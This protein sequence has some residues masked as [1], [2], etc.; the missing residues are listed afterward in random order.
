[1]TT[2]MRASRMA[3]L[4]LL[5]L[6]GAA[7]MYFSTSWIR[8]YNEV[9]AVQVSDPCQRNFTELSKL[10]SVQPLLPKVS[11]KFTKEGYCEGFSKRDKKLTAREMHRKNRCVG[12]FKLDHA[13]GNGQFWEG[14][15]QYIRHTHHKYLNSDSIVLDI[16]GNKG[17][18][19]DAMIQAYHPGTYLI[20]EPI[21][22]L[23][24]SLVE[25]FRGYKNVILY[26]FGIASKND[27]FYV[28][29]VGHGGDATSVFTENKGGKCELRVFNTTD[30]MYR[31]GVQC[32][33]VD[34]ITINCEG[35]EFDILE[36]LISSGLI[37]RFKHVQFATHPTLPHLE[38]P[39]ERYCEIQQKLARTHIIDYQYKFCWE[40]WRRK[41]VK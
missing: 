9:R 12:N 19:A 15:T 31:L 33:D 27:I 41:Y 2:S 13:R 6:G 20:L 23:F 32:L 24:T 16:G 11:P 8:S 21:N 38:R 14:E 25:K 36:T 1:M 7:V 40:T 3:K 34:L 37:S 35:C 17:E 29:V 28:N 39:V 18:D 10:E 4:V 26:N 22:S 30:F 5:I